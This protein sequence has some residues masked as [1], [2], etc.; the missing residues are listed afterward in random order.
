MLDQEDSVNKADRNK[1]YFLV[2]VILALLGTN[3]FLFFK[4][5]KENERYVTA[6]TEK[7]RLKLEVEKIE[8]ELDKVNTLNLV[9]TNKLQEEQKLAREKIEELKTE[10][11]KGALTQG[12]LAAAQKEVKQLREFVKNH[13][14]EISRLEKEN[15]FLRGERDS[16]LK[17]AS[18][19]NKRAEDLEK[20]NHELDKKVKTGAALKTSF[21]EVTAYRLKSNGKESLVT[22]AST[23]NKLNIKFSF[24]S[25]A[26]A[27]KDYHRIFLRV[28]D[29]TGNLIA[30]EADMFS[31]DGSEMQY[32]SAINISYNDDDTV[33]NID[34]VNPKEFLKGTYSVILYVDGFTTGKASIELR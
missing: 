19:A 23:A 34:W 33:Y 28:F 25:N 15:Y 13:S 9:L 16:L 26:L 32:S 14:D 6:N 21:V 2:V 20:I 17:S 12:D 4:D 30:N 22:R 1:I 29:P 18:S 27:A 3:A 24:A 11:Q 31:A 7:E 8:I 10:L 5:K